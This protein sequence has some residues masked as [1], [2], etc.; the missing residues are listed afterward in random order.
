MAPGAQQ[1][2]DRENAAQQ[3]KQSAFDGPPPAGPAGLHMADPARDP[4][5]KTAMARNVDLPG[6][7][8]LL[9]KAVSL[10]TSSR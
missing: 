7:A 1:E 3:L 10:D 8:F 4:V 5:L 6:A 2:R 9:D